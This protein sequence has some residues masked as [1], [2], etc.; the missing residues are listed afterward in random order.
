MRLAFGKKWHEQ[1]KERVN[2]KVYTTKYKVCI[3]GKSPVTLELSREFVGKPSENTLSAWAMSCVAQV[4][5]TIKAVRIENKL[6]RTVYMWTSDGIGASKWLR[7]HNERV[8]REHAK[9]IA[10][11]F[12]NNRKRA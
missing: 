11:D 6:G 10:S 7:Q 8:E 9:R 1:A 4:E 3:D 12:T 5:K 2:V